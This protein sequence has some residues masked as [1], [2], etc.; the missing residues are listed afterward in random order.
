MSRVMLLRHPQTPSHLIEVD[1]PW[2]RSL[3]THSPSRECSNPE[4]T[5][6]SHAEVTAKY[7]RYRQRLADAV[8]NH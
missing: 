2:P 6:A 8:Q 7:R 4:H 1:V 5:T 3:W